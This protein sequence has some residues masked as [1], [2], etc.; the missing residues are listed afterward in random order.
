MRSIP[1]FDLCLKLNRHVD[2]FLF[3]LDIYCSAKR[4]WS[5]HAYKLISWWRLPSQIFPAPR[6]RLFLLLAVPSLISADTHIWRIHEILLIRHHISIQ[7]SLA[8][9]GTEFGPALTDIIPDRIPAQ[10]TNLSL[11]QL[12]SLDHPQLHPFACIQIIDTI[13]RYNSII[14]CLILPNI[15]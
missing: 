3:Y 2:L 11:F 14:R 12:L 6:T 4:P 13:I 9:L 10:T 1:T 15:Y 7:V 8:R 5:R